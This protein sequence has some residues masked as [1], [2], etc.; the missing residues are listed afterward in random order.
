MQG[1]T[2]DRRGDRRRDQHRIQIDIENLVEQHERDGDQR[3]G[4]EQIDE[5]T[6]NDDVAVATQQKAPQTGIDQLQNRIRRQQ[7]GDGNNDFYNGVFGWNVRALQD[8]VQSQPD[9][10]AH[11]R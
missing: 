9:H 11:E 6:R 4:V 2:D 10:H 1:E 3:D 8:P 5:E 7:R